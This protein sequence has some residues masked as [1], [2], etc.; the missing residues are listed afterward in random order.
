[1]PTF[2]PAWDFGVGNKL[3]GGSASED[4]PLSD[5]YSVK[6]VYTSDKSLWTRCVVLEAGENPN[7]NIGGADKMDLRR[8]PSVDKNGKT[9][10][11][12]A[13]GDPNDADYISAIGMGWF[14]G[15]AINI[16]TG[17]RLNMM[18]AEDS[19]IPLENGGDMIWNPTSTIINNVRRPVF[20]G[21]HY[22]YVMGSTYSPVLNY[23][24]PR[25]DAG[26]TYRELLEPN[27]GNVSAYTLNQRMLYSQAMWVTM[28]VLAS[29]Y[30]LLSPQAGIVP[31]TVVV[32]LKVK[33]PY[34]NFSID[35][36]T[37]NDSMPYFTF[38]TRGFAPVQSTEIGRKALDRVNIV[39]N[40]YYAYSSY[41]DPGNQLAN[42]VRL[43]NLPERCDIR[44]YT[45]D[46]VLVRTIRKDDANSPYTEWDL[47]NDAKVPIS[48]GVYLIHI[49]APDFAE[50]R[51]IK[52]FGVMRPVD[53]DT[54]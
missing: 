1:M 34:A 5:L 35:G 33:R 16:E 24:G 29:G 13:S 52:W 53:F 28:P 6:V 46:G 54:F 45:M 23:K 43:V 17:E 10:D 22:V 12:V 39:P 48:S 42:Q 19:S 21:K 38:N 20:G 32:N 37:V 31:N 7:L 15:Y 14:P 30:S 27:P 41:E 25:Y 9:G 11:G 2:G 51:V 40:P 4:N 50:E 47:K 36:Q 3:G 26:K 49:K 44:I 8:S 18:F